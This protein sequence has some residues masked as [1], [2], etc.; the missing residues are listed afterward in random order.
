MKKF[1]ACFLAT[2]SLLTFCSC[3]EKS[4]S[5]AGLLGELGIQ[6][7]EDINSCIVDNNSEASAKAQVSAYQINTDETKDLME[8]LAEYK[9]IEEYSSDRFDELLVFPGPNVIKITFDGGEVSL[10]HLEN[11]DLVMR[12]LDD[13]G[14]KTYRAEKNLTQDK[15]DSLTINR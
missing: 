3:K 15:V 1:I 10:Y 4:F 13:S 2:L 5:Q 11:G 6:T 9:Y 12:S 8:I 14:F 7:I